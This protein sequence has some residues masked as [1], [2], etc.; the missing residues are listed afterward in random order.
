MTFRWLGIGCDI[1]SRFV[2]QVFL[3]RLLTVRSTWYEK[4]CHYFYLS[5]TS[6]DF[7]FIHLEKLSST[8]NSARTFILQY[9][10]LLT[11]S[12]LLY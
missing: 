8:K 5:V 2:T 10:S 9:I 7:I 1:S 12:L 4:N 6:T 11:F 3:N